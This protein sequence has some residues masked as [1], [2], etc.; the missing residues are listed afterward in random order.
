MGEMTSS[1]HR[2][3]AHLSGNGGENRA[4]RR[5]FHRT[6]VAAMFK[7]IWPDVVKVGA[8]VCKISARM[9]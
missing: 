7:D 5:A 6:A 9:C 1:V 3:L 8:Y 4:H 2:A